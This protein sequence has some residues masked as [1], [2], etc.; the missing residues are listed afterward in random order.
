[1]PTLLA[2]LTTTVLTGGAYSDL[3]GNVAFAGMVGDLTVSEPL[4]DALNGGVVQAPVTVTIGTDGTFT[5]GPLPCTDDPSLTPGGTYTL[6]WRVSRF[7]QCPHGE[8]SR[9]FVLPSSA[10]LLVD[11]DLMV[12]VGGIY[13]PNGSGPVTPPT[14][15]T[16][17]VGSAL[18]GTATVG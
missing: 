6:T 8:R 18:V 7:A 2:G 3:L 5:I 9:T 15:T 17:I 10:G 14:S 4:N 12:N 13:Y 1:M 16:A 11:F